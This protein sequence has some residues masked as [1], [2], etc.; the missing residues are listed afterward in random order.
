MIFGYFTLFVALVIS[1]VAEFYSI[2]GLTSIFSAAFWP[3]VIMGAA[4]GV[5]KITAAVWLKLNWDRAN[6]TYKL[7]LVPA[8]VFLMFLTSMGIFGYLSKAHSD[9][10]LVSGDVQSK[11]A[12]FDEKIKVSKEN[13]DANRK[14]LKQLDEAVDQVMG[15]STSEEGAVKAVAI[16]KSQANDRKRLLAEIQAE[17]KTISQLNEESAPIRAEVRKVEA[18][19]GP[20]KY[21][22]AMIYG[23]NPDAN[24]LESAV[25]WVIV[26]IVAVFDPLALML[27]LA[28]QQSLR[29]GR[30]EK[31]QLAQEKLTEEEFKYELENDPEL[32]AFIERSREVARALDNGDPIPE[33]MEVPLPDDQGVLSTDQNINLNPTV[34]PADEPIISK[35]PYLSQPFAHFENLQPMVYRPEPEP[36]SESPQN[37]Y[38]LRY[39]ALPANTQIEKPK[40]KKKRAPK[41]PK[42]TAAPKE[43]TGL[44]QVTAAIEQIDLVP[45]VPEPIANHPELQNAIMEALNN[46][47]VSLQGAIEEPKILAAG[48]D[49]VDRPGDYLNSPETHPEPKKKAK[50]EV[51]LILPAVAE[52]ANK[53]PKSV[54]QV[55]EAVDARR[56]KM[57]PIADNEM[58]EPTEV[59]A[60]FG[61]VFPDAPSKGELFLRVDYLPSRLFKFN[62]SKWIEVDKTLTDSY[63]Y[64]DEYVKYLIEE[65]GAGRLDI[66]DLSPSER[67]QVEEHLRNEQSRNAT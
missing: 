1:A 36:D 41:K 67:D 63:V 66:D 4:L 55:P 60:H 18:E 11:I 24:L 57:A 8:V 58:V 43:E 40:A 21:I 26:L 38:M 50:P 45:G 64:N 53:G 52:A 28:A 9:Q 22:A 47:A 20:I 5:G 59:T 30:K 42:V 29:W 25:R 56:S 44:E 54:V 15:R 27:I 34:P 3:V 7:Y 23:D 48:V 35:H 46:G 17:Q 10:N 12:I 51:K 6:W 65:I 33:A 19:V 39:D 16:R 37:I 61:I 13:I 32:A 49:V 2:V 31:E 62:G 14:A